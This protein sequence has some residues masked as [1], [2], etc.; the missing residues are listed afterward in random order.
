MATT[1]RVIRFGLFHH[2]MLSVTDSLKS[3]E[4]ATDSRGPGLIF[5]SQKEGE[6]KEKVVGNDHFQ[7]FFHV[8]PAE[9]CT[10]PVCQ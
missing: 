1:A 10:V 7:K 5:D 3:V 4:R 9:S 8:L 2:L 6:K